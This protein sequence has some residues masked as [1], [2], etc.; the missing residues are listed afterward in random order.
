MLG[1]KSLS[2]NYTRPLSPNSAKDMLK[3]AS[4]DCRLEAEGRQSKI[5]P[6][7][8]VATLFRLRLALQQFF[9]GNS[10]LFLLI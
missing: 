1:F 4:N 3:Q 5:G 8:S 7:S 10:R 9:Q 6:L 2:T